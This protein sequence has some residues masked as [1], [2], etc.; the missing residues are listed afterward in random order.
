MKEL[1]D[2]H[3]FPQIFRNFQTEFIGFIV[4]NYAI[5]KPFIEYLKS[6][7]KQQ[8]MFDLCSGSGEPAISIFEKS[9]LFSTLILSDKFPS[10]KKIIT[11]DVLN[12]SF[13]P[14]TCYTMFNA[15]HHFT[16]EEKLSIIK[17]IQKNNANGYFVEILEPSFIFL[18]KVF[19]TT[20]ICNL[21]LAPFIKPFSI[22]RLFFTYLLPINILS[23]TYDGIVSVCKSRSMKQYK[24]LFQDEN[25]DVLK[26]HGTLS[27]LILIKI[28]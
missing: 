11:T 18:I 2:F 9:K 19:I 23:I 12:T 8:T 15:F 7:P 20:T 26:L 5:Y 21:L 14:N 10:S 24:K 3:W 22:K 6:E 16:D 17:M 28:N 27:S 4:A 25:V 1:E 13:S